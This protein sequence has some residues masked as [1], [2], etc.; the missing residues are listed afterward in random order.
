MV[1]VAAEGGD[2]T[3]GPPDCLLQRRSEGETGTLGGENVSADGQ[4]SREDGGVRSHQQ[5]TG[6]NTHQ[7]ASS[8]DPGYQHIKDLPIRQ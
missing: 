6:R 1:Q 7:D 8:N 2:R 4:R 5:V 3:D